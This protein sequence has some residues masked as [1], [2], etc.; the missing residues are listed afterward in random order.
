ML[1]VEGARDREI[2]RIWART[3]S[4]L[5]SRKLEQITTIL[6]GRQPKRATKQ[7]ESIRNNNPKL[8]GLIVLD[9][10]SEKKAGLLTTAV[11]N[12]SLFTWHRRHI[13]S[14]LLNLAAIRKGLG[15]RW[16]SRIENFLYEQVPFDDESSLRN[17]DAKHLF[18]QEGIFGKNSDFSLSTRQVSKAMLRTHF[19]QDIEEFFQH[20]QELNRTI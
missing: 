9:R 3:I 4:P 12:L 11:T 6:G 17:F 20:F 2:L 16:N 10:D 8:K 14:Y 19:H 18:S 1:F 13:E 5:L 15:R 7:F